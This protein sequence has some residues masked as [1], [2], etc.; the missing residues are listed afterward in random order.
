MSAYTY[1]VRSQPDYPDFQW[2][3]RGSR[4]LL[5]LC[6]L[7]NSAAQQI[8]REA[9]PGPLQVL[10]SPGECADLARLL[11]ASGAASESVASAE[12]LQGR[13][14][15]LLGQARM[16]LR[17]YAV[18]PEHDIWRCAGLAN[19]HGMSREEVHVYRAGTLAR[20]VFCVHCGTHLPAVRT[21][22]GSCSGC[23]RALLVRDHF[24]R[25]HGAY[26]G[27]QAD[28]ETPGVLPPIEEVF[29]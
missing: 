29:P 15:A 27:I 23:G 21:N 9:C 13:L 22:I 12:A 8:A 3:R 6:G 5:V 25:L 16:G 11:A 28:A 7:D 20:P 18:G 4:H 19:Q 26:M 10:A 14:D 24:S 17:L 2:D 1:R